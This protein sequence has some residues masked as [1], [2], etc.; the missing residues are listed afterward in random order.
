MPVAHQTHQR[1]LPPIPRITPVSGERVTP[2]IGADQAILR[3]FNFYTRFRWVL[4][5]GLLP[6]PAWRLNFTVGL[7][8]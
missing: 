8:T 4:W 1:P 3:D 5:Q 2:V 7:D 6:A